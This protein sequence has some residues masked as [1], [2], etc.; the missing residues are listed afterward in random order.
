[1]FIFSVSDKGDSEKMN[2]KSEVV[3]GSSEKSASLSFTQQISHNHWFQF[4]L[5]ITVGS[6]QE[7]SKTMIM[8]FF[9][10]FWGG[11]GKQGVLYMVYMKMV[12][13][14][15]LVG[16][17]RGVGIRKCINALNIFKLV[18]KKLPLTLKRKL[19]ATKK[20]N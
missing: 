9:F 19:A 10:F 3:I 2:L 17:D 8:Q 7:K 12:T 14:N 13:E 15:S 1:M 4:P 20:G 6:S 11:G 5:G 18:I 16:R